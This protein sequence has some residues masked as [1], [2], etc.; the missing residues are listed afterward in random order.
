MRIGHIVYLFVALFVWAGVLSAQ[1]KLDIR[2]N[3]GLSVKI[4]L[5]YNF[6]NKNSSMNRTSFWVIDPG[7]PVNFEHDPAIRTTYTS[8]SGYE[9]KSNPSIWAN[10]EVVAIQFV[11]VLFD[12]FNEHLRSY[13]ATQVYD[14]PSKVSFTHNSDFVWRA[15]EHTVANYLTC[16]SFINRIRTKDGKVYKAD[17]NKIFDEIAKMIQ[18]EFQDTEAFMKFESN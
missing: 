18:H 8:Y 12:F 5:G 16:V 2:K 10:E 9:L 7:M 17:R 6:V 3:V 11:Y 4:H 13:R 14:Y 1:S 15:T